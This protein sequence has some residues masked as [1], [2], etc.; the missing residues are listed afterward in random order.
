[1]N[2][3]KFLH[4]LF[5]VANK[6]YI[7]A[8]VAFLVFY[9]LLRRRLAW[10]KIQT[11]YPAVADYGRE[12]LFSTLSIVIFSLPPLILLQ[13]NILRPHTTFYTSIAKYGWVYF[14]AAFPLMFLMHDTYF[15]W[16]PRGI[17]HPKLFRLFHVVHHR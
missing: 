11:R 7:I 16:M 13:N 3:E 9:V 14:Y 10:K 6:Y 5:T 4:S 2:W 1:M 15:Y 17:H 12:L 8:G